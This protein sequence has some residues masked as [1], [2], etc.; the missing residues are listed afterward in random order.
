MFEWGDIRI[1]LEVARCQSTLAASKKLGMNQTTVSRRIS[2]LEQAT[3]L[4]LFERDTRGSALTAA[5]R[6]LIETADQMRESARELEICVE[7]L[8]R[9]DRG[10]IRISAATDSA[11]HWVIPVT[12][13]YGAK[14]PGVQFEIWDTNRSVD[15]EHGEAEVAFRAAD[16]VTGDDLIVRKLGMIPWAVYCSRAIARDTGVPRSFDEMADKPVVNY[17]Q[18]VVSKVEIIQAF[19]QRLS[20][21]QIAATYRTLSAISASI[22]QMGAFGFLPV[23]VGENRPNLV[24]CFRE[25]AM[26]MPLWLVSSKEAYASPAVRDFLKFTGNFGLKDGLTLI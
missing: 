6:S 23:V 8:K 13:A 3:G 17:T 15:L 18:D 20:T 10:K 21:D 26:Q 11:E 7:G 19:T 1:F 22:G 2:A 12:A 16:N 9:R 14:N 4:D 24:Y 5:G 25:E